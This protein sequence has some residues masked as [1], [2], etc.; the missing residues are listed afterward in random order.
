MT[1][2]TVL[3]AFGGGGPLVACRI[4][5]AA[6]IPRVVIPGLAAVFS[7]FGLGFSDIAEGYGTFEPAGRRTADA[8]GTRS[9]RVA[10]ERRVVPLYRVEAL[11]A[12]A[13]G[14]GPAVLEEAYFTCRV[15]PGWSFT[16][17]AAGDILLEGSRS[18]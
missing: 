11:S 9:I 12:G 3:A 1:A 7:A 4:A 6:G 18:A 15:D 5:D 14:V 17:D 13:R 2:D 16:I 8:V 10:G